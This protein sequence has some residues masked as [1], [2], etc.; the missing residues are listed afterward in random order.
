MI[1][2]LIYHHNKREQGMIVCSC[3]RI[4]DGTFS[5]AIR[6]KAAEIVQKPDLEEAAR[7][8]FIHARNK[9]N[10]TRGRNSCT[11]CFT[12]AGGVQDLI[13]KSPHIPKD[14]IPKERP[15]LP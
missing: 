5:Q 14:K 7:V 4:S 13:K 2:N 11:I 12:M 3:N 9:L 1:I 15:L 6:E 8:A 10:P